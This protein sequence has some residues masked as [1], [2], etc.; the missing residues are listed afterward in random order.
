MKMLILKLSNYEKFG[1]KVFVFI[2]GI[3]YKN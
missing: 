2:K 1:N 3:A